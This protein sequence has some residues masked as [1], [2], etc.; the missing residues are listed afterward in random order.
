MPRPTPETWS[1]IR[2]KREAGA[3]FKSLSLEF[4]V[5]DA[6]IVKRAKAE[7]WGDGKDVAETI[8]RKVSEKVSAIVSAD[9]V[10]KA[11]EID[12]AADR[13]ADIIRRHQEEPETVRGMLYAGIETHQAAE[14]KEA[15][16]LAFEDLKAAKISSEV[17]L[18]IHR[19]ERQAWNLDEAAAVKVDLTKQ[20]LPP[21]DVY[22]RIAEDLLR[23]V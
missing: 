16:A 5:S 1:D 19:L 7:G 4:G 12:A 18:N 20:E 9:P 13:A 2:A 3:T 6:A 23:R 14:S 10:K 11:R 22:R 8:R 17:L 21:P 15:K